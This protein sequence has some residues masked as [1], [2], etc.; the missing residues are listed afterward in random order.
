MR[1]YNIK[2]K[3]ISYW[4]KINCKEKGDRCEWEIK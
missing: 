1:K 2:T 3:G 4:A